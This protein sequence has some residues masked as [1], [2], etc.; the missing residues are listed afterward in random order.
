M[1]CL[2][3]KERIAELNTE[4]AER[5]KLIEPLKIARARED[6]ALRERYSREVQ[7]RKDAVDVI[8]HLV[9]ACGAAERLKR[10]CAAEVERARLIA[11]E[12]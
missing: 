5:E 2:R 6:I 11:F 3:L 12:A 10:L 1:F 9:E 7:Y 8:K 4:I